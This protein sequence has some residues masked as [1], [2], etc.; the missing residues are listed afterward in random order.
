MSRVGITAENCI[1]TAFDGMIQRSL[2]CDKTS[3]RPGTK[4]VMHDLQELCNVQQGLVSLDAMDFLSF[5]EMIPIRSKLSTLLYP[6]VIEK[7]KERVLASDTEDAC[8]GQNDRKRKMKAFA[9]GSLF[10]FFHAELCRVA[11]R[12][13]GSSAS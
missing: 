9:A 4:N 2:K 7:A 11:S 8:N 10:V 1:S 12:K 13:S 6:R 5:A 3:I